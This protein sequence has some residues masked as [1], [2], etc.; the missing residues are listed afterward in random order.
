MNTFMET[1]GKKVFE[2]HLEQYAPSDPLYEY[3]TNNKGKQK[4][5]RVLVPTSHS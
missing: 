4:K 1:A 2:K 3:Y 5:R